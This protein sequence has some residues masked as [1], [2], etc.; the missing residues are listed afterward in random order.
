MS[1][2]ARP[3]NIVLFVSSVREQRNADR[4]ILAV[5]KAAEAKGFKVTL[6][7]PR[8]KK[9]PPLSVPLHFMPDPSKAPPLLLEAKTLFEQ[10]DGYIMLTAEYNRWV[11]AALTNMLDHFPAKLFQFRP[12]AVVS[13]SISPMGGNVA[14]M[15]LPVTLRDRGFLV[16]PEETSVPTVTQSVTETGEIKAD[17]AK[18]SLDLVLDQLKYVSDAM[19]SQRTKTPQAP[20]THGYE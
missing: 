18:S 15:L 2:V 5:K 3:L 4:V 1:A 13:Y 8:E 20:K 16:L 7:D 17:F 12:A 6:F 9:F 14:N 10:T 11:P 19:R